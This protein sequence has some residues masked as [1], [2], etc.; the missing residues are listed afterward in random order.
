DLDWKPP[1]DAEMKVHQAR[2]ERQDRISKIMGE[3]LLRGYKM[4]ATTC[5]HCATIL[6][7]DKQGRNYCIAC[8]ELDS[9]AD[10]DD[11]A[12]NTQAARQLEAEQNQRSTFADAESEE[13]AL[14]AEAPSPGPLLLSPQTAPNPCTRAPSGLLSGSPTEPGAHSLP[15]SHMPKSSSMWDMSDPLHS[16][17][18]RLRAAAQEL[19]TCTNAAQSKELCQLIKLC[20]ETMDCLQKVHSSK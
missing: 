13:M 12:L 10:K 16:V 6:M 11:P 19:S 15:H 20:A 17:N 5:P 9:D 4:L 18:L 2:R 14:R 3:Y 7:L 8:S 1:T